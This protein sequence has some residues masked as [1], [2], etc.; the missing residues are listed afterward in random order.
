MKDQ[1]FG[2]FFFI[3]FEYL[4]FAVIISPCFGLGVDKHKVQTNEV[5]NTTNDGEKGNV[6]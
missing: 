5:K 2:C 6:A 3:I 1:T 4:K